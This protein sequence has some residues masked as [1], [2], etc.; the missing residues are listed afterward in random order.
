MLIWPGI[1]ELALLY[2]IGAYAIL[3][4]IIVI[5]GAFWLPVDGGDTV[6]L[7]LSGIVSILFGIVMFASRDGALVTLSLIAAF[8]LVIGF[9]EVVFAIGGK[10]IVE[11]DPQACFRCA[12]AAALELTCPQRAGRVLL[13][14]RA[15]RAS[16]YPR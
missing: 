1:S 11:H 8:A 16:S 9:T 15:I 5:G 13:L 6:L 10:R 14:P 7:I 4:G 12:E 2:V 3:L